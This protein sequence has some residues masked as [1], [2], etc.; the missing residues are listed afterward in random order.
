MEQLSIKVKKDKLNIFQKIR[1]SLFKRKGQISFEEY[2]KMPEYIKRDKQVVKELVRKNEL[3]EEQLLQLP[4]YEFISL[5]S[6][7]EQVMQKI[8]K[9]QQVEWIKKGYI[10]LGSYNDEERNELLYNGIQ[11]GNGTVIGILNG[12]YVYEK[13]FLYYLKEKGT[14]EEYLPIILP[15]LSESIVKEALKHSPS[16][17]SCLPENKQIEIFMTNKR[18]LQNA[19]TSVQVKFIDENPECFGNANLV[20]KQMFIEQDINN[21]L[22]LDIE[23]QIEMVTINPSLYNSISYEAQ[24]EIFSA[25]DLGLIKIRAIANL[26]RYDINNSK[27]LIFLDKSS[28]TPSE[29]NAILFELFD[30]LEKFDNEK[31]INMILHSKM[32]SA[33]GSLTPDNYAFHSIDGGVGGEEISGIDGYSQAQI[34]IIKK[35]N[36]KQIASLLSIDSNY[37]LPYL[38]YTNEYGRCVLNEEEREISQHRCEELFL[39]IYGKE[40]LENYSN[41]IKII[42]DMQMDKNDEIQKIY[43]ER[44]DVSKLLNQ[45]EIPLEEFKI[46]FNQ[47]IIGKNSPELIYQYLKEKSEGKDGRKYFVKIITNAYGEKAKEILESRPNLDVHAINSLEIFDENILGEFGEAFVHDCISYNIR[48]FSEF[49]E[50]VKNPCKKK[51]FKTYYE[52]LESIYGENIETM[53]RAISEYSYVEELLMKAENVELTDTQYENLISVFCSRRNQ[54]NITTLIDLQNYEKIANKQLERQ[55]INCMKNIRQDKAPMKGHWGDAF[56]EIICQNFL[57]MRYENWYNTN[58][59]DSVKFITSLYDIQ[60]EASKVEDYTEDERKMLQV[61]DFLDKEVDNS[62]LVDF[63]KLLMQE[64]G[65]RCPVTLQSVIRKVKSRQT[66]ILNDSLLD[67]NKLK[68]L[69]ESEKERENPEIYMEQEDGLEIYHLNGIPF[70]FLAHATFGND[71][72]IMQY[73][74]QAGNTA[75]CT[76]VVSQ[77]SGNFH[78][79]FLYT[80]LEDDMLISSSKGDAGTTHVAKRVKNIGRI[81]TKATNI[82]KLAKKRFGHYQNE[83]AFYRRYRSHNNVNNDNNGGRKMPDAYGI[84]NIGFLDQKTKEFCKKYNIPIVLLHAEKYHSE[85]EKK[86][87][88]GLEK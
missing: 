82:P 87:T 34:Q 47:K 27:N 86:Q 26:L 43:R 25:R 5:F 76:R 15:R 69:C 19:S 88:D 70:T 6:K 29:M 17:L 51:N 75:I 49:L 72:D 14:L 67:I 77:D 40:A 3:T 30:G 36:A 1:L 32:F 41:C 35:L 28:Y 21:V 20:A 83:V 85:E 38:A 62:K 7:D 60:T 22:R 23:S 31:L 81:D 50:V 78:R 61:L 53:Q 12:N 2:M 24:N 13:E 33:I 74:G 64:N 10:K 37:I 80:H 54:F 55:I 71:D 9:E 79:T 63:A 57:G 4:E 42:F 56:K 16:L 66:Q 65:I 18:M 8:S 11:E 52:T 84:A 48:D 68:E 44:H 45:G 73:E 46:L 58:Y 59:G 39:N